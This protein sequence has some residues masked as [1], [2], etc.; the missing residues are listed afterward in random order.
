MPEVNLVS[1]FVYLVGRGLT[2]S[3]SPNPSIGPTPRSIQRLLL[4]RHPQPVTQ[5]GRRE[6]NP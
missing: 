2:T 4:F 6:S 3:R 5:Y 1:Y